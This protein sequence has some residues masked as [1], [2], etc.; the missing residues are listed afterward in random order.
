MFSRV[1]VY[2]IH[3]VQDLLTT[4]ASNFYRNANYLAEISGNV[5]HK[6]LMTN[7]GNLP[8]NIINNE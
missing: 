1:F 4:R 6:K 7:Y 3:V 8:K 2:R 5:F